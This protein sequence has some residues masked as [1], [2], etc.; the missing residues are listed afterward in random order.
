MDPGF[1]KGLVESAPFAET[2]IICPVGAGVGE[3]PAIGCAIGR[4]VSPQ[5]IP[6]TARKRGTAS[7][8]R[9]RARKCKL[10]RCMLKA[11]VIDPCTRV[12]E[13]LF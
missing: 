8:H 2:A 7:L 5:L 3:G 12:E 9:R 11:E 6:R 10:L 4:Y 1:K 13:L